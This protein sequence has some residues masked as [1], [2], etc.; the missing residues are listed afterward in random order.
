MFLYMVLENF[1]TLHEAVQ[2]SQHHLA[3]IFSSFY[4]R[5]PLT[6]FIDRKCVCV[7]VCVCVS[8]C[9]ILV[10]SSS[11]L[12]LCNTIFFSD[13]CFCWSVIKSCPTLRPHE[14][15]H[16]NLLVFYIV[17][18]LRVQFLQF[19]SF[20]RFLWLF[21]IFCVSIQI[22]KLFILV[23]WKMSLVF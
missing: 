1:I 14:L 11:C 8:R 21:G 13:N 18:S 10:R 23:L 6:T 3:K 16:Y 22:L 5:P 17:W 15:Q 7:C 9:S 19:C 20:S 12:F 2:F 4:I